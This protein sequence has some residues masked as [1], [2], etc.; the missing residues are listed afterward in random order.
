MANKEEK[1]PLSDPTAL[2]RRDFLCI[3]CKSFYASTEAIKRGIDPLGANMVVLSR[4]ENSGGLVLAASPY[5]KETYGVKLG[6]RRY[7]IKPQMNLTIVEPHMADYIDR[8]MRI[9]HIYQQFTD[10]SH[11]FPYSIDESFLDVSG[12][13]KLFG[14]NDEIAAR[15]QHKVFTETGIVTTVGIGPNPLLAKLALDN[16]AKKKTPWRAEWDYAD[17]PATVWK[18]APL[19]DMWGIGSRLAKRLNAM[20]IYTVKELAQ[21]NLKMLEKEFG[22]LGDQLYYHAWGIDY[23]NLEHRYVPRNENRGYGNSQVLMR[24]Y[25]TFADCA[26]II[27][28]IAHQVAARLRRH[29]VQCEIIGINI[30]YAEES[31]QRR[32]FFSAQTRVTPTN[33]DDEIATIAVYLF[34]KKWDGSPI[35]NVGVRCTRISEQ[36]SLQLN[37]FE[38]GQHTLD[39]AQLDRVIDNIQTRFGVK[40]LVRASSKTKGG[41]AIDRADLIGGHHA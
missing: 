39:R 25:T 14:D 24:D 41:T 20:G 10:R 27:R 29:Q 1:T 8:N 32:G 34:N 2:P 28:E 26:T 13:H 5:S 9:N 7:E 37:V 17:V 15:I 33:L 22:I 18:I 23:S 4:E 30:G 16:A 40:A 36:H 31:D 6:T 12:S 3:D 19:D 35:R 38:T 11:W 21:A